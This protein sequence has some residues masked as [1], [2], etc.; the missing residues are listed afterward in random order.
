MV[1]DS[2]KSPQIYAFDLTNKN[3]L[4]INILMDFSDN[5]TAMHIFC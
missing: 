1:M 3:I 2:T 5:Q 4:L